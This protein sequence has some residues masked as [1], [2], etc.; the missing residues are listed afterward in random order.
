VLSNHAFLQPE[1]AMTTSEP[2]PGN[3]VWL[4]NLLLIGAVLGGLCLIGGGVD[5]FRTMAQAQRNQD[6]LRTITRIDQERDFR[7]LQK[8]RQMAVA[9]PG[10]AIP[11][12]DLQYAALHSRW[13]QA[14]RQ[15]DQLM[16]ARDNRHL[17]ATLPE[18]VAKTRKQL[19]DLRI[20]CAN[21]LQDRPEYS[22]PRATWKIYNLRGCLSTMAA[23]LFLE[24]DSD[25]R[26]SG[27]FLND[28]IEDFKAALQ[29]ADEEK[30]T[31]FERMLPG[32]NLELVVGA[33]E[34]F[35]VGQ[36][37][38]EDNMLTVQ[39]QLEPVLPNFGGYSPGAPLD[40][41]VDK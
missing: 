31:T 1:A 6:L 23:Y 9:A 36:E 24:F 30:A 40:I 7:D 37:I 29:H 12:D 10:V 16:A 38:M 39:E 3:T 2:L 20:E 18:Y 26:E 5:L 11:F 35:A 13:R 25:G 4:K 15:F 32:W 14:L 33:G 28:A 8:L 34:V 41:F 19:L 27:K 17:V 22:T 21:Y